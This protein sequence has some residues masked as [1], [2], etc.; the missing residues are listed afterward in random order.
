MGKRGPGSA[1]LTPAL[2]TIRTTPTQRRHDHIQSFGC[3]PLQ[4]SHS[5]STPIPHPSDRWKAPKRHP[6]DGPHLEHLTPSQFQEVWMV[7]PHS[8]G[9]DL[10]E[11][12]EEDI[13]VCV[14]EVVA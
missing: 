9:R 3:D 1:C 6:G 14:D 13:I 10:S 7:V 2:L 8:D 5:Q 11:D 12:V 4:P